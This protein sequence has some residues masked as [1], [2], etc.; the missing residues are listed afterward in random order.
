MRSCSL[1]RGETTLIPLVNA[2]EMEFRHRKTFLK[3][4]KASTGPRHVSK[5]V[6]RKTCAW[7]PCSTRCASPFSYVKTAISKTLEDL[8]GRR[9]TWGFSAMG[10]IDTVVTTLLANAGLTVD[11]ITPVLV[12][13]VVVGADQFSNGRADAFFF[14]RWSGQKPPKCTPQPPSAFLA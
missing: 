7:R 9:V 10:S 6:H 12:P 4:P 3:R 11:D 8:R 14:C 1:I 2:G 5:G 13:N